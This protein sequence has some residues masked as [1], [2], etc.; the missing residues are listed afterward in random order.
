[1]SGAHG[2]DS[3]GG[4]TQEYVD[5]IVSGV[6]KDQGNYD[7]SVNTF[8]ASGGSGA[9]GAIM[10]G[11]MWYVSVAGTLDG[12]AVGVGDAVR[13]LADTPGQT[14][15]NWAVMEN[16]LG[17]V[18][19]RSINAAD[20]KT[21]PV[22]AD[23]L[24]VID[25]E[26]SSL[27]KKITWA[28]IKATLK[29]YFDTLYGAGW[30]TVA[31]QSVGTGNDVVI[32]GLPTGWTEALVKI[33]GLSHGAT[34]TQPLLQFVTSGGNIETGYSANIGTNTSILTETG[35]I[36][37]F[38]SSVAAT[39]FLKITVRIKRTGALTFEADGIS[40]SGVRTCTF[41]GD[42][43]LAS[44]ATGLRLKASGAVVFDGGN[45]SVYAR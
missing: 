12:V 4:V 14:A 22:D 21:T 19:E 32:S 34:A 13:A 31:S 3:G 37:V 11:D 6:L 20:A 42:I 1:M 2:A 8:P 38:W 35:G 18:P 17:Y 10:K 29:A 44:E 23:S 7:A 43:T 27:L 5:A 15:S 9:A 39:E 40:G 24:G 45:I 16:N 41:L 28:N 26:D 30:T 33:T 25:S 36:P